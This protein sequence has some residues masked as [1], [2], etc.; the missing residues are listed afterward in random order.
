MGLFDKKTCA[1][2]GAKI[3]ALSGK[4]LSDGNLCKDCVKQLSPWFD[5]YKESSTVEIRA[6]LAAREANREALKD[7]KMTKSFGEFGAILIDEEHRRFLVVDDTAT[8]L[9][10]ERSEV[11]TLEEVIDRN[12]DVLE[13]SQVRDVD[14][15]IVQTQREEKQTVNGEQVSY[16]PR[17]IRYMYEFALVIRV[18]HPYISAIRVVMNNGAVQILN[19]GERLKN[20]IGLMLAEYL[21]DLPIRNVK[22][23]ARIYDNNSL[24]AW[25]LRNP[26]AMPDYS[27]GFKCSLK[28]WK[29]IQRYGYYLLMV[30][31]VKDT[32][33]G[34]TPAQ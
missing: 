10:G 28:N 26:Y 16:D 6:Q 29:E 33:Q 25:L 20:K 15:D 27:Y 11:T 30:Q 19:E 17:H 3:G 18:E 12:P 4:K 22:T 23:E 32:L 34:T 7:F 9:F 13:F 1:V 8:S 21:L 24:K 5:A 31:E 2:C 14:I